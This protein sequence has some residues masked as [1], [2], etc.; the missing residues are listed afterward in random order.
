M[1][2]ELCLPIQR[3]AMFTELVRHKRLCGKLEIKEDE[4]FGP[5]FYS[6]LL[7]PLASIVSSIA[8]DCD[9]ASFFLPVFFTHSTNCGDLTNHDQPL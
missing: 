7:L 8:T 3:I 9:A 6:S 1:E 5:Y 2:R 4:T